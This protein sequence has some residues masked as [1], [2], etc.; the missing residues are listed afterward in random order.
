MRKSYS[1]AR[2]VALA[3]EI[4]SEGPLSRVKAALILLAPAVVAS[5]PPLVNTP[6]MPEAHFC[7]DSDK[8]GLPTCVT[9]S[10]PVPWMHSLPP[11]PALFRTS[12]TSLGLYEHFPALLLHVI[13][14][15]VPTHE[16]PCVY[17]CT[18]SLV[19]SR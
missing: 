10:L 9:L 4:I 16:A 17:G 15:F 18:A 3:S 6:S 1:C 14:R 13:T 7:I 8:L 11:M 5:L 12:L 19:P 2:D